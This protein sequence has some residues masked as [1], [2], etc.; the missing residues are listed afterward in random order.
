VLGASVPGSSGRGVFVLGGSAPG[1][2][3]PEG[4]V[5]RDCVLGGSVWW[6]STGRV[7][8]SGSWVAAGALAPQERLLQARSELPEST[9]LTLLLTWQP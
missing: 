3:A 1:G 8:L 6:T 2:F 4:S 5:P 9:P 7:R